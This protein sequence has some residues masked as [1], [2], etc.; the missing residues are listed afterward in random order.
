MFSAMAYDARL[1]CAQALILRVTLSFHMLAVALNPA[2][3]LDGRT[4]DVELL[5]TE[6][7]RAFSRS[8]PIPIP[9]A[10]PTPIALRR[11]LDSVV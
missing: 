2:D 6:W 1:R 4:L 8:I 5:M 3:R 7:H 11:W 9:I 10:T